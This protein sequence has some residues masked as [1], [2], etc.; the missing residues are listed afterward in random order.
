MQRSNPLQKFDYRVGK[1]VIAVASHHV[2]GILYIDILRMWRLLQEALS[3]RFAQHIR[4]TTA[5]QQGRQGER[6]SCVTE[7]LAIIIVNSLA[8]TALRIPV[9]NILSVRADPYI[10]SQ[11]VQ[12]ARPLAM[13]RLVSDCRSDLL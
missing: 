12:V 4:Q 9:P 1:Y 13:R 2:R 8:G 3:T 6:V 7:A 5:H 10:L 11:S